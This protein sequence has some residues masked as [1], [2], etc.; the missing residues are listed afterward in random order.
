MAST[1]MKQALSVM[2]VVRSVL[3]AAACLMTS[4]TVLASLYN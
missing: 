1:A 4:I 3:G 2:F